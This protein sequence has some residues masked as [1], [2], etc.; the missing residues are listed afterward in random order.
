MPL[1]G[2]GYVNPD[3]IRK[4]IKSNTTLVVVNHA[5]N[6]T[7]AV[8]DIEAIGRSARTRACRWRLMRPRPP[9]C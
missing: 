6:V 5:S 3:D 4:A 2:E 1:D 9:A 8:Q 7:G